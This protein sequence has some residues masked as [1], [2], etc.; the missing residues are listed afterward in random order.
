MSEKCCV[1]GDPEEHWADYVLCEQLVD[2]E[3]SFS[4]GDSGT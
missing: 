4:C 3:E 2:D 1:I